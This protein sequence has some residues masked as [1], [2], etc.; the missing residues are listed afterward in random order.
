MMRWWWF[1]PSVERAEIERELDAMAA[2]GFGGAELS[3][4]YP[5]GETSDRYLSPT[6]LA[7]VRFAAEAARDRGL[8]FDV[9]LG[10]GWS[11]GGP[12]IGPDLAARNVHWERL[13]VGP[14]AATFAVPAAWPGDEFIAAYI[15]TGSLQEQPDDLH[16]LEV[17]DDR[18]RIPEGRGPRVIF[19]AVSRLTGQN[20]KRAALGAEGPVFD[21]YSRAATLA[22]IEHVAE[23]LVSAVG[24]ELLGSVFCDS[25]EVY[26]GDWT[27]HAVAEFRQRRGYDPLPLLH[28]LEVGGDEAP[29][30]RRDLYR[31]LT[32]L[33]EENF[34]VPLQRWAAGHGVPFRI[35][36]YGE[37]P[38]AVSS[39]RF[40]DM[41]EG[42][43]WGW[44][45]VTQTRWASSAAHLYGRP[46][47]SSEI[48]TWVHSPSF[49]ATPLDLKGEAH[50]HI[51]LGINHFI[52]HG[53]PY[54]PQTAP[55]IGWMFY[56]SGALDDR[57]PWW[58]AMPSLTAYLHRLAW[59]MRQGEPA[60]EVAIYAPTADAYA[61]MHSGGEGVLDLWRATR[62]RIGD[63][64]PRVIR[65]SGRDFDLIDDDAL[66]I[67]APDRYRA[68]VLPNV[69]HLPEA[70]RDWLERFE[71]AG[72]SIL[73]VDPGPGGHVAL[74]RALDGAT[75]APL[76]FVPASPELGVVH[77]VV[78]NA[79]VYFVA[80]TVGERQSVEV[81][82][83]RD[84]GVIERWDAADGTVSQRWIDVRSVALTLQGYE[85]AVFVAGVAGDAAELSA[86]IAFDPPIAGETVAL[87][88]PWTVAFA[89]ESEPRP[90]SLPH[91][92][93]DESDRAAYSG[94]ATYSTTVD[95]H[96]PSARALLDFGDVVPIE[97]DAG[98]V[99][100]MRG[101]S[102]RARVTTPIGEVAVV[103]V[104]GQ[105]AGV[106]WSSP[107][108]IDVAP[109]LR[110]GANTI[111]VE[112]FNTA[113]NALAADPTVAE[114]AAASEATHGRRF[115]MQEL[116]RA[117]EGVSSGLLAVP[118]L[119][120]LE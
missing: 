8:R 51:L 45:D 77:R 74:D 36:G 105:R 79:H 116:H 11:F 47:V 37:P 66:P 53:W 69:Q 101:R 82:F 34:L 73:A 81:S 94:S 90:I 106:V 40:A 46:V 44:K 85:A 88:G 97:A 87:A 71:D 22:H 68:I 120:M 38:A 50:E 96:S 86:A 110:S 5:I 15:G 13:E 60:A 70:A 104:N 49:R 103:I 18:I 7:D 27:P 26:G 92:W 12:H 113:A 93:E 48:W 52:G 118:T 102:F 3:V 57:N 2:G 61:D 99:T 58:P 108:R 76:A 31:T 41:I 1:G 64:I 100:G 42:E 98:E 14:V 67:T 30:L 21:H 32:E 83:A 59:L 17:V 72:G 119:S 117:A 4:V 78:G 39:Y 109:W 16:L 84:H 91:R 112:V 24:A 35:Q 114:W 115:R 75:A 20:V 63:V 9:T 10:S 89:G 33:Y 43:G 25:L 107:Y 62:A 111:E 23:P 95:I 29:E 80:N 19:T 65:E 56:A 54:S 6:F 28:L 55:G